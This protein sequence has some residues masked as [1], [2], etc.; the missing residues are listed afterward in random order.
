MKLSLQARIENFLNT[1]SFISFAYRG[2]PA[3]INFAYEHKNWQIF[4]DKKNHEDLRDFFRGRTIRFVIYTSDTVPTTVSLVDTKTADTIK[5]DG[6]KFIKNNIILF[7]E[8]KLPEDTVF[9]VNLM[10]SG[11]T[12]EGEKAIAVHPY[13]LDKKPL[14]IHGYSLIDNR[15]VE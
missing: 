8:A 3:I 6:A 2:K 5:I 11:K 7:H 10:C 14:Q 9:V 13:W 15:K 12:K 1:S 4:S